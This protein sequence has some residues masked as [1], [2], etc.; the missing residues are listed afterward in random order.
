MLTIDIP[1]GNWP[2]KR[3][4]KTHTLAICNITLTMDTW[5]CTQACAVILSKPVIVLLD[6]WLQAQVMWFR[7]WHLVASSSDVISA[8]TPAFFPSFCVVVLI[9]HEWENN[10]IM[11][12]YAPSFPCHFNA[13]R[14]YHDPSWVHPW[15]LVTWF[16]ICVFVFGCMLGVVIWHDELWPN[17]LQ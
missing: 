13:L 6:T 1:C 5:D 8:L 11:C 7:P 2:I 14:T 12:L 17:I 9:P 10:I 15:R 16:L 3:T 4:Y